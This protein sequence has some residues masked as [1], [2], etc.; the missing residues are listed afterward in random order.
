[1]GDIWTWTGQGLGSIDFPFL[2]FEEAF[3][4]TQS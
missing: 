1:M 2:S 4:V 3:F